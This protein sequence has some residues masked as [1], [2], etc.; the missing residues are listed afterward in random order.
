MLVKELLDRIEMHEIFEDAWVTQEGCDPIELD[1]ADFGAVS[2]GAG[3]GDAGGES[4]PYGYGSEEGDDD[5]D[6]SDGIVDNDD[7]EDD[8]EDG[9]SFALPSGGGGA[10]AAAV[11]AAV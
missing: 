10:A 4:G 1:M 7:S 5:D 11:S 3:L 6:R 2:E 8:D 9:A